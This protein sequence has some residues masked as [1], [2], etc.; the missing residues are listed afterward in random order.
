[1]SLRCFQFIIIVSLFSMVVSA[2]T[3]VKSSHQLFKGVIVDT[4]D[5]WLYFMNTNGKLQA[6]NL[7]SGEKV[8]QTTETYLPLLVYDSHLI[9]QKQTHKKGSLSLV[10]FEKFTGTIKEERFFP[11]PEKVT[12]LMNDEL[13]RHFSISA[14]HD[15]PISLK[16]NWHYK[17]KPYDA[18]PFVPLNDTFVISQLNK[19][20]LH[21]TFIFDN[22]PALSKVKV[23]SF[24]NKSTAPKANIEGRFLTNKKVGRQFV[25]V[26]K[27]HILLSTPTSDSQS[28]KSYL[29]QIY[30]RSGNS[31]GAISQANSYL[32]FLIIKDTIIFIRLPST[33]FIN[34]EK[35]ESQLSVNAYALNSGQF[36]WNYEIKDLS[37]TGPIPH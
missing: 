11:L 17:V 15:D 3:E 14:N 34:D 6:V 5:E 8:W 9:A 21:G 36:L 4:Q 37:Y 24:L 18:M 10:S 25:S 35:V 29:W 32:P 23:K 7:I 27:E 2:E 19:E 1:M 28:L 12:P 13:N 33:H 20:S 30:D 26:S 31:I 22:S 16:L